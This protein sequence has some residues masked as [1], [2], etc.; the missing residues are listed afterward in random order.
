MFKKQSYQSIKTGDVRMNKGAVENN[1]GN[2]IIAPLQKAYKN[3]DLIY[4]ADVIF[5]E[6]PTVL[7]QPEN[8]HKVEGI[9]T[10]YAVD[11][12]R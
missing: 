6:H 5:Q 10:N 9:P 2:G 1:Q 8:T 12:K 11:L 3:S 7:T 4:G